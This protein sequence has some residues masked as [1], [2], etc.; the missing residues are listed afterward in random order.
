MYCIFPIKGVIPDYEIEDI[1]LNIFGRRG[2]PL[3][4]FWRMMYWMPKFKNASPWPLPNPVPNDSL[5]LAKLAIERMCTVDLLSKVTVYNTKEIENAISDTWIVSGISSD[6]SK[7]LEKHKITEPIRI[8]G[9]YLIWL[10]NKSI[11]YFIL[12]GETHLDPSYLN[13]DD[14]DIDGKRILITTI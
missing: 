7:L 9:P 13:D 14:E 11:S 12:R 2:H 6:Q 4:K 10:R 1:L 8:E 5:E 3:R